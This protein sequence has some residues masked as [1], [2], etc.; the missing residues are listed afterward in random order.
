MV[1]Y[2]WNLPGTVCLQACLGSTVF[3]WAGCFL[4]LCN[5][6][7]SLALFQSKLC[8]TLN[9]MSAW[10]LLSQTSPWLT[11]SLLSSLCLDILF[12]GHLNG[13]CIPM[14]TL[15]IHLFCFIFLCSIYNYLTQPVTY[16]NLLFFYFSLS[17]LEYNVYKGRHFYLV[18]FLLYARCI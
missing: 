3:A 11:L 10:K 18:L 8:F 16:T 4:K 1:H 6:G 17:P 7:T 14:Q 13:H 12:S 15:S 9:F 5:L 2:S